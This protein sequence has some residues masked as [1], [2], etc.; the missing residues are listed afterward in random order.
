MT[1]N[2]FIVTFACLG[3]EGKGLISKRKTENDHALSRGD[4][5]GVP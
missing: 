5:V 2:H 1:F 3:E 4:Y